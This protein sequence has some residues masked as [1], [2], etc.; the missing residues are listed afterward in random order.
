MFIYKNII[1]S[2]IWNFHCILHILVLCPVC[3]V[4]NIFWAYLE[5]CLLISTVHMCSLYPVKNLLSVAHILNSNPNT[6]VGTL[7]N[8]YIGPF[9]TIIL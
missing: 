8:C 1:S 4:S 6:S 9:Y 3:L 5:F 7:Q 2:C